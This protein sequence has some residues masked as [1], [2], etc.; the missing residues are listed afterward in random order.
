MQHILITGSASG[1]GLTLCQYFLSK[2]WTVFGTYRKTLAPDFLIKKYPKTFVPLK[3]DLTDEEMVREAFMVIKKRLN[4]KALNAVI[5]NA[6]FIEAKPITLCE[7][8]DLNKHFQTNVVGP[9]LIIKYF[10]PLLAQGKHSGKVININSLAGVFSLPFQGAYGVSKSGLSLLTNS[11]RLENVES[12]FS[13]IDIWL[14]MVQTGVHERG[15]KNAMDLRHTRFAEWAEQ[16]KKR[17]QQLYHKGL[18][19]DEVAKKIFS[20]IQSPRNRYVYIIAKS[21][22]KIKLL[23]LIRNTPLANRLIKQSYFGKA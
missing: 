10:S 21:K 14:G 17:V 19:T 3:V 20:I 8:S 2:G 6:A 5:N 11:F 7:V 12:S 23:L 9:F 15:V 18:S 16:M 4:N 1:L 22:W 13:L